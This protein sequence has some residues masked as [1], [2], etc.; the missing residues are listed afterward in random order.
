M[1]D[2]VQLTPVAIA[3]AMHIVNNIFNKSKKSFKYSNIPTAVFSNPN[4]AC[5]GLTEGR[6][7]KN[8][9]RLMFSQVISNL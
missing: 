3:E 2:R 9:K 4:F 1:I 6:Q 8:S 5:I 7:E